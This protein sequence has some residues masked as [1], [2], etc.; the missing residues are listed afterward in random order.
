MAGKGGKGFIAAKIAAGMDKDKKA[1][2]T[3]SA[4]AGLQVAPPF[5]ARL[6][7]FRSLLCFVLVP[8]VALLRPLRDEGSFLGVTLT[9]AAFCAFL[10]Y[11]AM[12]VRS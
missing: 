3:R 2:I 1:P 12:R 9:P 10:A 4:R 8:L 7:L 6:F 5:S 11:G